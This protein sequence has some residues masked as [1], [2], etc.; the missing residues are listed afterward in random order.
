MTALEYLL[1]F[2]YLYSLKSRQKSLTGGILN[3]SKGKQISLSLAHDWHDYF[4][5]PNHVFR[6]TNITGQGIINSCWLPL[7]T[8]QL[9]RKQNN[10]ML[11][12]S[13]TL[14]DNSCIKIGICIK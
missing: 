2:S 7:K 4:E 5:C 11:I 3:I 13:S 1:E 6:Q 14:N 9:A 10:R 8:N 12:D